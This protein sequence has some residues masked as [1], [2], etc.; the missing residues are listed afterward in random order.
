M[1]NTM[2][3]AVWQ[4]P[5]KVTIENVA[6]PAVGPMDVLI[7]V[8]ASGICGSDL[9]SFKLGFYTQPGQILGHEF[10][11]EVAAVGSDVDGIKPGELV[12]G[13]DV[14][15]CG[16]CYWCQK[17]EYMYCPDLFKHSTGYGKPGAMAEYVL[18]AN[19][20][21]GINITKLPPG[22]DVEIGATIEPTTTAVAA[23][24]EVHSGDNVVILGAG[25][26]GNVAMQ[27]AKAAGA[28]KVIVTEISSIRL[29]AAKK[30]GADAVFDAR[31]GNA[32]SWVKEMF[33]VGL[34][35]FN[36]GGMADVVIEAAGSPQTVADAFEMVRSRGTIVFVGLPE[37]PALIDTTKIVHKGPK[38]VGALGGSF[39][40]A[41]DLLAS[42]KVDTRPLITHRFTLDEAQLAF[43]TA[44]RGDVAI[45]VMLKM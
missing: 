10:A 1:A 40:I 14:G 3:A 23:V 18:I 39:A 33:G 21:V 8:L 5:G 41:L 31:K 4:A 38:I 25:L 7:K 6:I 42:G 37:K 26:I 27:G 34:Y 28:G 43:E 16:T 9:H 29:E 17:Q 11:G 19:A 35:H 20:M 36:E 45:K 44:L 32:L 30:M 13:F 12:T 24:A 2:K 15:V 22:M